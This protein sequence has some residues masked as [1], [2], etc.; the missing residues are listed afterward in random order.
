M[1]AV[2]EVAIFSGGSRLPGLAHVPT[3][4]RPI[5]GYPAVVLAHGL[6]NDRDEAGQFPVLADRLA[7]EGKLV[8][9]FDFRGGR[10]SSQM[11]RQLPASEWTHDLLA[12]IAYTRHRD[13]VDAAA[14]AVIGASAGGAVALTVGML[15]PS[16][17]GV[18]AL[19]SPANGRRWFGDLWTRVH[20]E[21]AWESFLEEVGRDRTR[22]ALG[23]PSRQLALAGEFLPVP[24]DEL[25]GVQAFIRSNPGML[26]RLPLEVADDLLLLAP[27]ATAPEIEFPVLIVHGAADTLVPETQ[28]LDLSTSLQRGE[29]ILVEQGPHQLL[30]GEGRS[31]VLDL[32]VSWLATLV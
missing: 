7:S 1:T 24:E 29:R 27:D 31:D 15:E 11:G 6:A 32:L 28:S 16:L 30:L 17:R 20:G 10:R 4:R 18:A 2:D 22:R 8:V 9:R 26:D 5:G 21:G 19:G 12:A 14:V 25:P 13:D 23:Q 3:S